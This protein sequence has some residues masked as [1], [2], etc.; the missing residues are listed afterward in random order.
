MQPMDDD[1]HDL[2]GA[3][4]AARADDEEAAARVA[5]GRALS[6]LRDAAARAR[7]LNWAI[8]Q[9]G[10]GRDAASTVEAVRE[11]E[12]AAPDPAPDTTLAVDDLSDLFDP[13]EGLGDFPGGDKRK[14]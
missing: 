8:E 5:I 7:V 12:P 9:F 14:E 10:A 1:L 4:P 13:S 2:F 6:R 3:S 11:K